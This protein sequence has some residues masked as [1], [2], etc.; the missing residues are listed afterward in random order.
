MLKTLSTKSVNPKKNRVKVDNDAGGKF[1][2][3]DKFGDNKVSSNKVENNEVKNNK[4]AKK[5]NYQKTSKSK[6][7]QKTFKYKKM[8]NSLNFFIVGARLVFT[9]LRQMFLKVLILHYFNPKR[10]I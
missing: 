5:K 7:Y 10:N 4:I 9:M 2:S 6:N 8:V 1:D 3:R